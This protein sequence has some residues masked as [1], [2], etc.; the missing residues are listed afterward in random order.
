MSIRVPAVG[1]LVAGADMLRDLWWT[2]WV[3]SGET[4]AAQRAERSQ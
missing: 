2:A 4:V 3:R 1:R